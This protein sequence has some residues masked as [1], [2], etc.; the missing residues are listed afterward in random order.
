MDQQVS[1]EES[2][3]HERHAHDDRR[4]EI[5]AAVRDACAEEGVSRFSVSSITKRVGCTRSLFYHYFPDKEA[6]LNA[7][8]PHGGPPKSRP[9]SHRAIRFNWKFKK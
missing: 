9:A 5:L 7:A 1:H 8:L 2:T 4:E 6:A 3:R